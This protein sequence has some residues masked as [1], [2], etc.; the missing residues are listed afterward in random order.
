MIII[1]RHDEKSPQTVRFIATDN[2]YLSDHAVT[3][4]KK[5]PQNATAKNF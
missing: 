3:G 2:F 5:I 1:A 4:K